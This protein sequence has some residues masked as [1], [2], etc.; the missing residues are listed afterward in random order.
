MIAPVERLSNTIEIR[1]LIDLRGGEPTVQQTFWPETSGASSPA[2]CFS[3]TMDDD[4]A[5]GGCRPSEDPRYNR[6]RRMNLGGNLGG[7]TPSRSPEQ[8]PPAE[9]DS[10]LLEVYRATLKDKRKR[11]A[12]QGAIAEHESSMRHFDTF[13]AKNHRCCTPKVSLSQPDVLPAFL[14]YLVLDLGL[15]PTTATKRLTHVAMVAKSLKL[16]VDKPTP[17]EVRRLWYERPKSDVPESACEEPSAAEVDRRIPSFAE[18]DAIARHVANARY[19]YGDHAPYFWRG[20]IRLL[21]FIGPRSR[22]VV[23]VLR[24]KPGLRKQDVIFDTVCP[25]ADVSNALGYELHSPHGWLWYTIGKD[26]HSDCRR[27]LFPMP[28]WLRDWVRFFVELS[29]DAERVFPSIHEASVALSQKQMTSAWNSIVKAACVDAR[30]VPSEGTG[31]RI[32]LRKYA[33]NWWSLATSKAKSDSGLADKMSHY[34]LHHAEVTTA[35]KHY[36]SVQAA[37]LPVMLEL[38]PTWPVP[39]ADAPHVSLLPE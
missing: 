19:P 22:D 13:A 16:T 8:S 17:E 25:I 7:L 36:L 31:G 1:L 35:N 10:T 3:G 2:T 6:N 37:V 14:K 29:H 24:R 11:S 5:S 9:E 12:G 34:V 26:T 4:P 21:A 28:K 38:L 23:S 15:A 18:I 27:I 39:A 30:L 32:A 33:A 20:W